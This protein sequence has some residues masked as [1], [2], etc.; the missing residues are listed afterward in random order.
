[1]FVVRPGTKPIKNI[2]SNV[3]AITC[4]KTS[5]H[6]S[7]VIFCR[8]VSSHSLNVCNDVLSVTVHFIGSTNALTSWRK[9]ESEEA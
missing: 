2:Q 5:G 8:V 3:S 9:S 4:L 1:M 6:L 7:S